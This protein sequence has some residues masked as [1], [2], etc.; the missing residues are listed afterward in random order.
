MLLFIDYLGISAL[1]ALFNR[2]LSNKKHTIVFFDGNVLTLF[3]LK[4]FSLL[5]SG[6][7]IS[8]FP[9]EHGDVFSDDNVSIRYQV[10]ETLGIILEK[11]TL[12]YFSKLHLEETNIY[13][14]FPK[15]WIERYYQH[16]IAQEIKDALFALFAF[17]STYDIQKNLES[18]FY[19]NHNEY[20]R[21][22]LDEIPFLNSK[23]VLYGSR[24][25]FCRRLFSLL[26]VVLAYLSTIIFIFSNKKRQN[27][28]DAPKPLVGMQYCWGH[29][30]N[31][32]SDL[33]WLD[34]CSFARDSV[35]FYFDRDDLPLT[36]CLANKLEALEI[37]Y[38]ARINFISLSY[39]KNLLLHPTR[40]FTFVCAL[41]GKQ[42]Q[43]LPDK[44]FFHSVF[45]YF[46]TFLFLINRN[47][48]KFS[49]NGFLHA[50]A[51]YFRMF[52]E[53]SYWKNFFSNNNIYVH[54]NHSCDCG[55]R[56]V[57]HS[58]AMHAINRINIRSTYSYAEVRDPRFSREFHA[59][60]VWGLQPTCEFN[61]EIKYSAY[62]LVSGYIF[63]HLF[64]INAL[65]DDHSLFL[66]NN[67]YNI[68]VFDE[69]AGGEGSFTNRCVAQFYNALAH[70]ALNNENIGL[71][72]KSKRYGINEIFTFCPSFLNLFRRGRVIF[73]S[74]CSPYVAC[75]QADIAISLGINSAGVEA[76]LF[77][78][79]SVYW[80][81]DYHECAQ[82]L[83]HKELRLV[84]HDLGLLLNNVL[85]F[86]SHKTCDSLG[87][88]QLILDEIDPFR[89]GLAGSR[90]GFFID[91][92]L[93]GYKDDIDVLNLLDSTVTAYI[94][95]YGNFVLQNKLALF[96]K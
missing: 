68:A 9:Y 88:H 28:T 14:S 10:D 81:H 38:L 36:K 1:F 33:F 95:K 51:L 41:F 50:L 67:Q 22:I 37:K 86:L 49:S 27:Y 83:K 84:F 18:S 5:T 66:G 94:K 24:V 47:K 89:D 79:P 42:N 21:L 53:I 16:E 23:I 65:S 74:G 91:T 77:G 43:W 13:S 60:F 57:V 62:N 82:F 73:L 3:V 6:F 71:V 92:F 56:H 12:S 70:F 11:A 58:L 55:S 34:N 15:V 54:L 45:A 90:I 17:R 7:Q 61:T 8:K 76:A 26:F 32:R 35:L 46:K 69:A 2:L 29:E 25:N 96:S 75:L 31:R 52:L 80:V 85:A 78:I 39:F 87:N 93:N 63:S 19:L 30:T 20:T 44:F 64:S 48:R 72:I 59:F 40:L 4:C